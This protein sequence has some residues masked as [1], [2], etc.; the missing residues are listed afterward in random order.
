MGEIYVLGNGLTLHVDS[1]QGVFTD[2]AHKFNTKITHILLH[3]WVFFFT[4]NVLH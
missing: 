2:G 1:A 4:S 3:F